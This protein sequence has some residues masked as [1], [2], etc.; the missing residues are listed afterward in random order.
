MHDNSADKLIQEIQSKQP[1]TRIQ[2][3]PSAADE[4]KAPKLQYQPH[5]NNFLSVL[6]K[7]GS[8]SIH[9]IS[10][11][12]E[13]FF[14]AKRQLSVCMAWQLCIIVSLS[15]YA[16]L[17]IINQC[18]TLNKKTCSIDTGRAQCPNCLTSHSTGPVPLLLTP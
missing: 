8:V 17:A 9:E 7:G 13:F 1:I 14:L 2:V 4:V 15:S 3:V 5:Q 16:S 18:S 10:H 12:V 6:R 11:N